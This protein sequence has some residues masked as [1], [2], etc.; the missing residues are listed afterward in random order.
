MVTDAAG[1]G[2]SVHPQPEV[3]GGPIQGLLDEVWREAKERDEGELATYI[4]ELARADRSTFGLA[5]A[6]LDGRVYSAGRIDEFTIQSVSKP[7]VYALALA[8]Q[9]IDAMLARVGVEPTGNAFNTISVDAQGRPFNP[10]VNAG[11]IVTTS[12]VAGDNP[13]E[14][15]D[16]VHQGL[17]AFAGRQLAVDERVFESERGT[18]DRNRAIGFLLRS[19]GALQ[20]EVDAAL[21]VYFRQCSV[22]VDARDLAVMAATLANGGVNPLTGEAVVPASVVSRVLTVMSTCGMY[23]FAGEWLYRVGLPA[24]SGVSGGIAAAQPGRLGFGAHSPLLDSR[25][26]SVRGIAACELLSHRLDLHLFAVS[27]VELGGNHRFVRADVV[28]SKRVRLIREQAI[29]DAE[30]VRIAV[31]VLTGAQDA[32]S[33]ERV[34]RAVVE[35]R[36]SG[37]WR[38]FDLRRVKRADAAAVHLLVRLT[39]QLRAA[40]SDVVVVPPRSVTARRSVAVLAAAANATMVDPDDA[41]RWCEDALL[42]HFG[43]SDEPPDSL[44]PIGQQDLLAGLS[45]STAAAIEAAVVTRVFA[46][47]SPVF[48]EGAAADGLYFVAA[49][50][51]SAGLSRGGSWRRFSTMGPGSSFGELALVEGGARS[52]AVVADDA[53]LCFVL[54]VDAFAK[55]VEGDPTAGAEIYRS[56]AAS[57]AGRV[58]QTSKEISALDQRD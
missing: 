40:G 42:R 55:L 16:R 9:G 51:V 22:L 41:L 23:D 4:P 46:A 13:S 10:M 38:V 19:V 24:K 18:G 34:A 21:S 48:A 6:S 12:L 26:N 37:G 52:A 45:A 27:G 39:E 17:S 3:A 29:L 57:L 1:P 49:G 14:Q 28:R 5:L 7:F 2:A 15:F 31:H 43:V 56:I 20:Q 47:G 25:G 58:R 8:D 35:D 44:V 11:A 36:A 53:T 32:A 54:T 30:G 33:I 50:Q